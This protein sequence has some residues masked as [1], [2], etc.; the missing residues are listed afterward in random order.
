MISAGTTVHQA[1]H[2]A[3]GLHSPQRERR[4][5]TPQIHQYVS[6]AAARS[7]TPVER[8]VAFGPFRLLPTRRL[9]LEGEKPVR[10]G[11]R[12]FDILV[13]LVERA[14]ELVSKDELM[15]RVWPNTFVEESNL[16]V[17]VAGLRRVLGDRR[18]SNRYVATTSGRGYRSRRRSRSRTCPRR[19]P[20]ARTICQ[21]RSRA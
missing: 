3:Q 7:A 20:S 19:R 2:A 21:P 10:L 1:G 9:L 13:A 11:S 14:G 5:D 8:A 12:A 4:T 17:Q 16:K 6:Q 18:G 15:A